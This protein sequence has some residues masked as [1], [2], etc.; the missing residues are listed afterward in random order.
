M[1]Q[2]RI[3]LIRDRVALYREVGYHDEIVRREVSRAARVIRRLDAFQDEGLLTISALAPGDPED[4][5][6]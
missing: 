1:K 4:Q 2:R 6:A 3:E 5:T